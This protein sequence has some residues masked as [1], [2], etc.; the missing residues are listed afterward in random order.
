MSSTTSDVNSFNHNIKIYRAGAGAGKTTRLVKEV[1]DFYKFFKNENERNPRVVLTTFTRKATQELRERLMHE[2]QRKNDYDFLNFV[3]SKNHLFISTIHGTLQLFLKQFAQK[4]DLDPGFRLANDPDLFKRAKI[5]LKEIISE[6]SEYQELLEEFAFKD[7][8]GLIVEHEKSK[9]IYPNAKYFDHADFE[10][11]KIEF[12]KSL[13]QDI[14]YFAESFISDSSDDKWIDYGNYLKGVADSFKKVSTVD[15]A[16]RACQLFS[17]YKKPQFSKKNPPFS[18]DLNKKFEKFRSKL[19]VYEGSGFEDFDS[20]TW[21]EMIRVF[22]LFNGLSEKFSERFD[23][24]KKSMGQISMADLELYSFEVMRTYPDDIHFFSESFD[25]WLID[26]FQDTSP[27]QVALLTH[28]INDRK[29]FVVGDPQQS[30]YFFRGARVQVFDEM[31][32]KIKSLGGDL[33]SLNTN[34]RSNQNTMSFINYFFKFYSDKF[35]AMELGGM[36]SNTQN[37]A[38]IALSQDKDSQNLAILN[39]IQDVHSKGAA[40]GEICVLARKNDH[41]KAVAEILHKKKIPYLLHSASGFKERREILDALAILKFLVNPHDN[42][43]LIQVLRSPWFKVLDQHIFDVVKAKPESFWSEF[44][45]LAGNSNYESIGRMKQYIGDTYSHGI[46]QVFQQVLMDTGFFDLSHLYDSSGRRESN[47]WKLLVQLKTEDH[48]PG[49]NYIDFIENRKS[50]LDIEGGSED[51]D[52]V[53]S[54]EPNRVQLMTIHMSKG[55]EFQHVILPYID[56]E[57]KLTNHSP[58]VFDEEKEKYGLYLKLGEEEGKQSLP[59]KAKLREIREE[60]LA[61]SDRLLYVAMTRAKESLFL[62]TGGATRDTTSWY[63][64]IKLNLVEGEHK[65]PEFTYTVSFGPWNDVEFESKQTVQTQIYNPLYDLNLLS[66]KES[67]KVTAQIEKPKHQKSILALLEK[68]NYGRLAHQVFEA[69]KYNKQIPLDEGMQ[70]AVKY[71]QSLE[72]IPMNEIL[73]NGFAEW[74]FVTESDGKSLSG[75]I[76]LWGKVAG[77]LWVIDYKTGTSFNSD[78]AFEQ[79]TKYADALQTQERATKVNL[80]ALYPFE[81]KYILKTL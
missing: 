50:S 65:R 79:L 44:V 20:K 71:I 67:T 1:Y 62:S 36:K 12:F 26:E 17:E 51:S 81:E 21:D 75:Q 14:L 70:R 74:G 25:Y 5:I 37:V 22:K 48:T 59:A 6:N 15:E 29:Y 60:E 8:A 77:E 10:I 56:S 80:V 49:F 42:F 24:W 78:L 55:L 9:K 47:L 3:L 23:L 64:K 40:L 72:D 32:N 31:E 4:I 58:Y 69:L 54:I 39:Y 63:K 43:N 11:A 68:A 16:M 57:P 66:K 2:A 33:Y 73:N 19:K 18:E 35:K 7:L 52:A 76:D 45:K 38:T 13:A 61:E 41:L 30:I 46:T 34:Y 27:L 28:F 53:S